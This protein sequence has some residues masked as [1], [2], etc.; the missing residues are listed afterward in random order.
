[1]KVNF[2]EQWILQLE[3]KSVNKKVTFALTDIKN[4]WMTTQNYFFISSSCSN[5]LF[6]TSNSRC[7]TASQRKVHFK[8]RPTM[9][10]FLKKGGKSKNYSQGQI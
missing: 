9:E 7:T 6:G 3:W 1:M 8:Y 2:S 4:Y 10:F 5:K